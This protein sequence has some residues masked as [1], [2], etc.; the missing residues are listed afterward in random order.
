MKKSQVIKRLRVLFQ[1]IIS[2][3]TSNI[4]TVKCAPKLGPI[5]FDPLSFEANLTRS[6]SN[7]EIDQSSEQMRKAEEQQ[8][9]DKS[10]KSFNEK[11]QKPC[12]GYEFDETLCKT[13]EDRVVCGYNKNVGNVTNKITDL[14]NGCRIRGNRLECGYLLGP[15]INPR[16]PPARDYISDNNDNSEQKKLLHEVKRTYPTKLTH[17]SESSTKKSTKTDSDSS[18]TTNNITTSISSS[19]TSSLNISMSMSS[20]VKIVKTASTTSTK[21]TENSTVLIT[22]LVVLSSSGSLSS[23]FTK[24]PYKRQ[25]VEKYDHIFCYFIQQR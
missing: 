21:L 13:V 24:N 18:L 12:L 7:K 2:I 1:V 22:P 16:R 23:E 14:G 8:I 3:L 20:T 9:Y 25:C 19:I 6:V 11:V 15:F 10:K 4:K 5:L 17:K